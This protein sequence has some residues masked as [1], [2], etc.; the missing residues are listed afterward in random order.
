M[1]Y[2]RFALDR[3]PVLIHKQT[4]KQTNNHKK[5]SWGR[6]HPKW[7]HVLWD[8]AA[9]RALFVDTLAGRTNRA[10]GSTSGSSNNNNSSSTSS[11]AEPRLPAL[12]A[13]GLLGV[14]DALPRAVMRADMARYA[15]MYLYG[16]VYVDLGAF[17]FAFVVVAF[18]VVFV[19]GGGV[20]CM[21]AWLLCLVVVECFS[22]CKNIRTYKPNQTKPKQISSA[23]GRS[24]S[25]LKF[26]RLR[27]QPPQPPPQLLP[28]PQP[29]PTHRPTR[30]RPP[31]SAGRRGSLS[32]RCSATI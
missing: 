5:A 25:C 23:C 12:A 16:G 27:Q 9:N 11:G 3:L 6:H 4:N 31:S 24:T 1:L 8:D 15:Y 26:H 13:A 7:R 29:Q 21:C 20:A 28:Q 17:L 30:P 10:S 19:G 18:V 22:T 14:Y 2:K 32:S